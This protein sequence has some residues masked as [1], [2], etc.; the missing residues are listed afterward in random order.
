MGK[1]LSR[2]EVVRLKASLQKE[3]VPLALTLQEFLTLEESEGVR[4]K[5][6]TYKTYWSKTYINSSTDS[7]PDT[8]EDQE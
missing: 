5:G 3:N 1:F 6:I 7:R 2:E 8:E 4:A